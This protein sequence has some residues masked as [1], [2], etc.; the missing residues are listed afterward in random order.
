M[1]PRYFLRGLETE[2]LG[3]RVRYDLSPLSIMI[4]KVVSPGLVV[5]VDR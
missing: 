3:L 5:L 2:A 4:E 1:R